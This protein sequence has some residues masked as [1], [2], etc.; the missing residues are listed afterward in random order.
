MSV[1]LV[2][3]SCL[4]VES[5]EQAIA[6]QISHNNQKIQQAN[7][8]QAYQ[9]ELMNRVRASQEGQVPGSEVPAPVEEVKVWPEIKPVVYKT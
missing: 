3:N 8:I 6:D 2:Y 9:E 4:Y 1:P 5:Q 7:D